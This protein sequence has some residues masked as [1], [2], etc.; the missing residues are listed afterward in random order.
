MVFDVACNE[1]AG[2]EVENTFVILN[3][4]LRELEWR[5]F[6]RMT[7]AFGSNGEPSPRTELISVS[8]VGFSEGALD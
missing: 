5:I 7:V 4:I 8:Q 3:V 1:L 2:V 6:A